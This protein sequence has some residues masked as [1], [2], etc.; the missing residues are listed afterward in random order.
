MEQVLFCC[1]Y[2]QYSFLTSKIYTN[3]L[4]LGGRKPTDHNTKIQAGCATLLTV[5]GVS[6]HTSFALSHASFLSP[7]TPFQYFPIQNLFFTSL[8]SL[9]IVFK[10]SKI[11]SS[12]VCWFREL[13]AFFPPLLSQKVE[14][15]PSSSSVS[16]IIVAICDR[17]SGGRRYCIH[18]LPCGHLRQLLEFTTLCRS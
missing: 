1:C 3:I 17:C 8:S 2:L 4:I 16:P 12:R 11:V 9:P 10:P 13:L 7:R 18:N 6:F 15:L 14:V 5:I